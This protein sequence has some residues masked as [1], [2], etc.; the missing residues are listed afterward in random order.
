MLLLY[1]TT[2]PKQIPHSQIFLTGFP[3]SY[4]CLSKFPL[5]NHAIH[6]SCDHKLCPM[7]W[8]VIS[9]S[10]PFV[11]QLQ[12]K[13][14]T[15]QVLFIAMTGHGNGT[16]GLWCFSHSGQNQIFNP[17]VPR[18]HGTPAMPRGHLGHQGSFREGSGSVSPTW[19]CSIWLI[20]HSQPL[21]P[22]IWKPFFQHQI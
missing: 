15:G 13:C 9:S 11:Y 18:L 5:Q 17:P 3:L 4:F 14:P 22:G 6:K 12:L 8:H 19:A 21:K 16:H 7:Q 10:M 1:F 2:S 20:L